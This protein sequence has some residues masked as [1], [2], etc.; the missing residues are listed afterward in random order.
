M[1]MATAFR[2][3]SNVPENRLFGPSMQLDDIEEYQFYI[4]SRWG[5]KVF[6]TTNPAERW[7]G[8]T[9][10]KAAPQG[11]YIYF[12]RYATPGDKTQEERGNFT[13]IR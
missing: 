13:L 12:I 7:D 11:V 1:F 3:N 6:E 4:L 9:D 2:P 10:G 5:K 8:T